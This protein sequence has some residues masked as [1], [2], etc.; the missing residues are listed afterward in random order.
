MKII[1]RNARDQWDAYDI[2]TGMETAGVQVFSISYNGTTMNSGAILA[3]SSYIV[4]GRAESIDYD[5]VD[6]EITKQKEAD[7]V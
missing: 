3:A 2:A 1:S 5:Q 4:W 7:R 6:E